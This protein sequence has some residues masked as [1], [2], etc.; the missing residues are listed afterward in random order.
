MFNDSRWVEAP[1]YFFPCSF[2]LRPCGVLE[3]GDS[4]VPVKPDVVCSVFVGK[5]VRDKTSKE[6]AYFYA[7]E[8]S[9]CYVKHVFVV[10]FHPR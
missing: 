4:V 2:R 9:H 1:C 7:V 5:D 10:F 6:F 3:N 8:A